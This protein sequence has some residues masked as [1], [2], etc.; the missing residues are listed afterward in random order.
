[1]KIPDRAVQRISQIRDE[2]AVEMVIV[3]SGQHP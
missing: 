1:M 2:L 3:S